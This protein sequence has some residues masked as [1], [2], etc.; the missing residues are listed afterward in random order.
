MAGALVEFSGTKQRTN[1]QGQARFYNVAS[2]LEMPYLVR[3]PDYDSADGQVDVTRDEEIT[4]NFVTTGTVINPD[5]HWK[6]FPNPINRGNS[7]TINL[8]VRVKG[9]T[10]VSLYGI[11]GELEFSRCYVSG[12][13]EINLNID[14]EPGIYILKL[15]SEN[16]EIF[17]K[18]IVQK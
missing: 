3:V 4:V 11:T 2:L 12:I 6:F 13:N 5:D 9:R 1:D 7:L 17:K 14:F 15:S 16:R 18:L 10:Q 8:P